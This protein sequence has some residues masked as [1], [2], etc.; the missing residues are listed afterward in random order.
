VYK[1]THLPPRYLAED[2]LA[3]AHV[4]AQVKTQLKHVRHKA[5]NVLL[6]GMRPSGNITYVPPIDK[7]SR[8][9]YWHFTQGLNTMSDEEVN[10]TLQPRPLLRIRFAFMRLATIHN[11]VETADRNISQWDQ[12]DQILQQMRR[13]PVNYTRRQVTRI[14]DPTLLSF[15]PPSHAHTLPP[16]VPQLAPTPW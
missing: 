5:R 6:T 10:A 15:G 7:L 13:L 16:T 14:P 9:L 12:M 1:R 3:T 8:M 2:P 4:I 11:F